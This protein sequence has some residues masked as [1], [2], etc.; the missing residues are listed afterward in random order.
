[1]RVLIVIPAYN[2]A[3]NLE[4]VVEELHRKVPEYDYVIVN[5][6]SSDRTGSLCRQRGFH[7][8]ELS[9]NL[10]L[11]GAVQTGL[12][13]AMESGYDAAVQIDGDGQHDPAY[14]PQLVERMEKENLDI[15]IGSRFVEKKRPNTARMIGNAIIAWAIRAT[16][17]KVISDPTSGMRL[18]GRRVLHEM[19]YGMNYRPEPDTI[20]FLIR[21]G[22][23]VGECQVTMRERT[24]GESYLGFTQ[25]I[26][27]MIQMCMNIFFIQWV[28]KKECLTCLSS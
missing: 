6:G 18:Y 23:K 19:A 11:T 10:G 24:R 1:M 15:V 26:R 21:Q 7:M 2:E 16:T 13:Y 17:G 9:A 12:R 22:A 28:R 8:L 3:E 27:Y 5:D 20:A 25:S 4:Q 14:L